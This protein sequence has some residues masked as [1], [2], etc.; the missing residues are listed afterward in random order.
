MNL[1]EY[2]VIW[3]PKKKKDGE[4]PKS[5]LI[6]PVKT[7]LAESQAVATM[8]AT[9]EIPKAYENKLDEVQVAVRPF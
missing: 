7:V 3:T 9:R 5:E 1:F 6:V 2:A 8:M 4:T